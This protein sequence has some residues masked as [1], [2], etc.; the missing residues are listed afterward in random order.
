VFH[1]KVENFLGEKE[2]LP[3]VWIIA[4]KLL[5]LQSSKQTISQES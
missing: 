4:E 2:K 3:F 1:K 5:I